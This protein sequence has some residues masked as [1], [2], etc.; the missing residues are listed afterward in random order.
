[1]PVRSNIFNCIFAS[2]VWHQIVDKLKAAKECFRVLKESSS[3]IIR[4]ISHEQLKT[5]TVFKYFRDP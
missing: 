3:L 2:Q 5:K 4:T 1:M